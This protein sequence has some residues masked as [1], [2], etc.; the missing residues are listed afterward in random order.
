VSSGVCYFLLSPGCG[1]GFANSDI[2]TY[3]ISTLAHPSA[4]EK[5]NV[6]FIVSYQPSSAGGS[7]VR[8]NTRSMKSMFPKGTSRPKFMAFKVLP[9][10]ANNSE[11]E[12][13][14]GVC[15][16]IEAARSERVKKE[17][18]PGAEEQQQEGEFVVKKDI[19]G[20]A[21]AKRSTGLLEQW[22]YSLRKSVWA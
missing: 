8:V 6:G 13:V 12:L 21:E 16:E 3:I 22:G 20:L 1:N 7:I 14:E 17:G 19:I 18:V 10:A 11:I 9:G 5:R 15:K 2:G 4:D